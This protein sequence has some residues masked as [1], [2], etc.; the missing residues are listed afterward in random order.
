MSSRIYTMGCFY[1]TRYLAD[2]SEWWVLQGTKKGAVVLSDIVLLSCSSD[3]CHE[4]TSGY[5]HLRLPHLLM[6][7]WSY[8]FIFFISHFS[9][10]LAVLIRVEGLPVCECLDFHTS[11][12]IHKGILG[13]YGMS[14]QS[15]RHW[16]RYTPRS[17]RCWYCIRRVLTQSSSV[18]ELCLLVCP[19]PQPHSV[20][21]LALSGVPPFARP[22]FSSSEPTSCSIEISV[23]YYFT[24]ILWNLVNSASFLFHIKS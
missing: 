17:S 16:K 4:C 6:R 3:E 11:Q 18:F 20:K 7:A 14:P 1:M 22:S 5:P 2:G 24:Y 9:E 15:E 19:L 21:P 8:D 23:F 12:G 13:K 10:N